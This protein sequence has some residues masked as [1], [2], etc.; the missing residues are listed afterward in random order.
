MKIFITGAAGFIGSNFARHILTNSD[1]EI[2]VLD[3]LTYAGSMSSIKDLEK[4]SRFTFIQGDICDEALVSDAMRGHSAVIHFAAESHVDRSISEPDIFIKT[5]C[6][7]TNVLCNVAKKLEIERFIHISTDEVYGSV[8]E[9]SSKETDVLAPRSP[10][11]A[12]KAGSDLIALSYYTTHHLPVSIVR[13]T[14]NYGPFQFP[15]KVIPLFTTNL[16]NNLQVPLYGDGKNI[17][18][19]CHVSD[20]CYAIESVLKSGQIGEIYNVG[21]G[22]EI[23]NLQLTEMLLN[24][25]NQDESMI[26]FVDDRAGHDRRYS[27]DTKK[28]RSLGWT[29]KL[30]LE[31]GL[32]HTVK[33]YTDNRP[34]WEE[35]KRNL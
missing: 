16:L 22:N 28:I 21:A 3:L 26:E 8:L 35:L 30:S 27:V 31:D 5:N 25:M 6:F 11:S 23:T 1:D 20:N 2:T 14:N 15:E 9:G 4:N 10:Y 33:W 12:S 19:W 17:R 13:S 29:P 24:L 32:T 34:W 18:D 7:G